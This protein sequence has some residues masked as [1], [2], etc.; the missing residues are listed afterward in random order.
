MPEGSTSPWPES[1]FDFA[2]FPVLDE[3]LDELAK[4]AEEEDW[5]YQ[6]STSEHPYPVLYKYLRYT[7]RRI[8]EENKIALSE[9]GQYAC[10]NSG[11]VTPNQEPLY[12]S[13]ETNRRTAER[14]RNPGSSKGGFAV[15]SGS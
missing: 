3:R 9:D 4:A 6:R 7:Y 10:F 14:E 12:A 15:A 2:F 1:V 8:A 11:L 5:T 13:F